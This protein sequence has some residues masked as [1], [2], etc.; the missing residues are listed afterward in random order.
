MTVLI[1]AWFVPVACALIIMM[2]VTRKKP[3][4][5]TRV[6]AELAAGLLIA[7]FPFLFAV[8]LP[9]VGLIFFGLPHI[10]A[11]LLAARLLFGRL[12]K[13]FVF[14]STRQ[15]CIWLGAMLVCGMVVWAVCAG[16]SA[17]LT[18]PAM[19]ALLAVVLLVHIGFLAQLIWAKRHFTITHNSELQPLGQLP[20]VSVCIP[21]RNEDHALADCL[22]A[23]LASDYP[24]LEVLVLDDCSQDKTSHIIKSFAHDGV[25]FIQGEVPAD[26]WLG[27]N[28]ARQTLAE[29][30]SG[31][32][33][34]FID[35]DTRLAPQSIT[36]LIDYVHDAKMSMLSVLPQN[37]L[38]L[39]PGA[40][41]D[42][43]RF[44]WQQVLP[45][46]PRRVPVASQ[47]WII[48]IQA[49]K[50]LG[51]FKSVARKITP[52]ASFARRLAAHDA[53]RFLTSNT[54]LGIT[55][56]KKWTS[57]IGSAVRLLYPTY[58]RQPLFAAAAAAATALLIVIPP[59]AALATGA[60]GQF[61]AIFAMSCLAWFTAVV[62]FAVVRAQSHSGS[63]P[64]QALLLPLIG[65]QEICVIVVSMFQYEFGEVNWK[66]RNICYPVVT[67]LPQSQPALWG[68]RV[69]R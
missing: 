66:G 53:Y 54:S 13:E 27:K 1:L 51:G 19:T 60:M 16:L 58:H 22:T 69:R 10:I 33:L 4:F 68:Q 40:I 30:A 32:Y 43:L 39:Q 8:S 56:A 63:W 17:D 61:D 46:T 12:D 24:K 62:S 3:L 14:P 50:D 49:F 41:F 42:T 29:H 59:I 7:A 67:L 45:I 6:G 37:R 26:G 48:S 57:V 44:Y 38:G 47:A 25:R 28:Q 2:F 36:Q 65:L 5:S 9:P 20:T 31:D 52:E 35:V 23:V 34:L 11:L 21:A 55:T 64:L 15:N 18:Y